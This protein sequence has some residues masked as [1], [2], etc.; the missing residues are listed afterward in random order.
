[1]GYFP[2][3]AVITAIVAVVYYFQPSVLDP[4]LWK[5]PFKLPSLSGPYL[6]NDKLIH[7]DK[8]CYGKCTAPESMAIDT[9]TGNIYA[10][11]SDGTVVLISQEGEIISTVFFSGGYIS[12]PIDTRTNGLADTQET[13][14]WC[15]RESTAHRLPA[16]E[17]K[18]GRPLGL[19]LLGND[20]YI[21]D[22]YHGLFRFDLSHDQAEHLVTPS[23]MINVEGR[24]DVDP[25]ALL[26]PKFYNDLDVIDVTPT[27]EENSEGVKERERE[28]MIYFSDSSYKNT[29]SENRKE[30]L[31]GAPRGRL[32]SYNTREKKLTV[33]L[34]GLHFPNG[35]Q[36][37][38]DGEILLVESTRFRVLKVNVKELGEKG[39]GR[40][41]QS[42]SEEGSLYDY[43]AK[44]VP[45]K[46]PGDLV[47]VFLDEV[48]GFMDNIRLDPKV[49]VSVPVPGSGSESESELGSESE[50][51]SG[52]AIEENH[53][54][55]RN[56]FIGLGITS[57]RP[58]S[59]LWISYQSI[60]LRDVIG[61][62][63]PMELVEN[64]VPRYGLV[65]VV[66]SRCVTPYLLRCTFF[67]FF[68]FFFS[69]FYSSKLKA[70]IY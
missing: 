59:V 13:L 32:F 69:N 26:P 7:V 70:T 60:I 16:D 40:L 17:K 53:N 6:P 56:F 31:D 34:C 62:F 19:R 23:T 45:G 47:S 37:M 3:A 12:S 46:V 24:D 61:K 57:S 65:L 29:R 25:V 44:D 33:L 4:V 51:R 9:V 20:L 66:N 11:L 68:R 8:F 28:T 22:A 14:T 63:L 2:Y 48:P 18:C 39:E 35:V 38:S 55:K 15:K 54:A 43:L 36:L 58:F 21:I 67:F 64:L 5:N 49:V 42:C 1:M 10:S 30:V 41:L 50:S 27:S 52:L